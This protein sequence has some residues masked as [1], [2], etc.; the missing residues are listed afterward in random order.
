[1]IGDQTIFQVFG[2]QRDAYF[3]ATLLDR[4]Q[5]ET[6]V[7]SG[8][9]ILLTFKRPKLT[10]FETVDR[11]ARRGIHGL[12]GIFVPIYGLPVR[13]VLQDVSVHGVG[14]LASTDIPATTTG[15]LEVTFGEIEVHLDIVVQHCADLGAQAESAY[16]FRT[17]ATVV[18]S[19]RISDAAWRRFNTYGTTEPPK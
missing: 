15:V 1:V 12:P 8:P 5:F 17:G 19:D 11:D 13:I 7:E 16:K 18:P 14:F 9:F 2:S 6:P 3:E 4:Q 10:R